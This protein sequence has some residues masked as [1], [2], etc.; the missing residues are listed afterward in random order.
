MIR[1]R[2]KRREPPLDQEHFSAT[3]WANVPD[4]R[5]RWHFCCQSSNTL[6]HCA[7]EIEFRRAMSIVYPL[8]QVTGDVLFRISFATSFVKKCWHLTHLRIIH[9]SFVSSQTSIF[10]KLGVWQFHISS[11]SE[12]CWS[13]SFLIGVGIGDQFMWIGIGA[14]DQF[15]ISSYTVHELELSH[16]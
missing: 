16:P 1:R 15:S 14:V 9:S 5:E 7:R 4:K 8:F 11:R 6:L 2:R 3:W 12:N 13:S 10:M